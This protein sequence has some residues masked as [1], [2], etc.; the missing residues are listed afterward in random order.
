[1]IIGVMCIERIRVAIMAIVTTSCLIP[2]TAPV[3]ESV[4]VR[5]VRHRGPMRNPRCP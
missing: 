5:I 4:D 3:I 1:M 2:R